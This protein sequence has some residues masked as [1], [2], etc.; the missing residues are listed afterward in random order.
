[1]TTNPDATLAQKLTAE[2]LGTAILVAVV[3][4]S[5]I[6]ADT[7]SGGNTAIALLGNTLA[8]AAILPVLIIIFAPLSGAHFNPAVSLVFALRGTLR[9]RDAAFYSAAQIIG[10]ICGTILA[11]MM[12][13]QD[14]VSFSGADRTGGSIW[15]SEIIAAF[16]LILTILAGIRH[17]PDAV[18]YMVGLYIAA[19]YWFTASTCFANPAVT[20]ARAL[21]G[22]FAGINPAHAPAFI[23]AQI[24]GALLAYIIF[25]YILF[26]RDK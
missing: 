23:A 16:G 25:R 8:T 26:G 9:A 18:P 12:F 6:M 14:I 5:G 1:V 22:S 15:L 19:G 11:H 7:L 24:V 21:T 17:K 13:A 4:G 2:A 10:G 20:I 3:V